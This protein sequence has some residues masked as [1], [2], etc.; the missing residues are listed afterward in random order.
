MPIALVGEDF[1][2]RTHAA[3]R[4]FVAVAAEAVP[5]GNDSGFW[6]G[7]FTTDLMRHEWV[8]NAALAVAGFHLYRLCG[9]KETL[10]F[11]LNRQCRAT[12][13]LRTYRPDQLEIDDVEAILATAVLLIWC[14]VRPT[15]PMIG[16]TVNDQELGASRPE[17]VHLETPG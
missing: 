3:F 6:V 7:I 2:S 17:R 16:I 10:Q 15:L 5:G 13:S 4:H 9:N 12:S 8:K 1:D 11:S 14:D